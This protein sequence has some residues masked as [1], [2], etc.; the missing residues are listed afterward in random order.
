LYE[1]LH[2]VYLTKKK[3]R[4]RLKAE[5]SLRWPSLR[6]KLLKTTTNSLKENC[7]IELY[8]AII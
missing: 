5:D 8:V 1:I 6:L 2:A 4:D 3:I 7:E